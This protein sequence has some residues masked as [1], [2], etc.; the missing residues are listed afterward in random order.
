MPHRNV[1]LF[2]FMQKYFFLISIIIISSC[3]QVSDI[4][5]SLIGLKELKFNIQNYE[6]FAVSGIKLDNISSTKDFSIVDGLKLIK[7]FNNKNL[8]FSFRV[9]VV[10][11]NP[12]TVRGK[13]LNT[14]A[15]ITE[16]SYLFMLDGRETIKGKIEDELI[17]PAGGESI[18]IPIEARIDLLKFF[19]D[20]TYEEVVKL[21]L[22]L[23]GMNRSNRKMELFINPTIDTPIGD[24]SPGKIKVLSKNY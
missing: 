7:L 6:N 15:K 13:K 4:T 17:V 20:K 23:G 12:N 3:S 14:R 18:T 1:W 5:R 19:A 8:I 11:V 10:A 9:N 2:Y 16:L 21:V 24:L 22:S